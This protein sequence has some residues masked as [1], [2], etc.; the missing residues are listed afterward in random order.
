MKRLKVL[1]SAYACEP[2]KGS[3]PGVGWNMAWEMAKYH[4]IWVITRANNRERIQVE[5]VNNPAKGL[6]FVYFDLP[7]WLRW[8][9]RRDLGVQL[10]YYLW[11][12]GIYHLVKRLHK[13][14]GFDLA[15]H[16]T[17]VKYWTPSMLVL[18]PIPFLWG[19]V[20]GG[21]SA[22]KA[23]WRNFSLRGKC[24]EMIR[25]MA[26]WLGERDPLVRKTAYQSQLVLVATEDTAKRVRALGA[27]RTKVFSQVGLNKKEVDQLSDLYCEA[28]SDVRFVSIG[29]L[30]HWK[31]FH[32]GLLSLAQSG[33]INA[34]Y[35]IIG[36][37]PERRRLEVITKSLGIEGRVKFWGNLPRY[38]ALI[39]LG[40][41]SILIHP[42]FHDSGGWVCL[43]AMAAGK[44]VICLDLGGPAVMVAEGAGFKI[45]AHDPRQ[46]IDDITDAMKRLAASES[47]RKHMGNAGRKRVRDVFSWQAKANDLNKIYE[48]IA[49]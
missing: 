2:G 34:E 9:K 17:F 38:E 31:G 36:H 39:K 3:E 21:E 18:L 14:I 49:R 46:V 8:W 41:S 27:N 45:P 5:L 48:K 10:Y 22:P 33:L 12:L 20:G 44:P 47:L 7:K 24:Y 19:P 26:R 11:Q 30:L 28:K 15:H 29:N 23:F 1:I 6:H 13:D 16:V 42:S 43:E 37:G 25:D 32:L 4:D 35:W 40:Q